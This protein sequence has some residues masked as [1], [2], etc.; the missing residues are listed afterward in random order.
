MKKSPVKIT[1]QELLEYNNKVRTLA[2]KC[3]I[4]KCH[5][6]TKEMQRKFPNDLIFAY[7]EA[8]YSAEDTRGLSQKE[9]KKRYRSASAKLRRLLYRLRAIEEKYRFAIRNEYYWFSGQPRK[10]FQL[11]IE[12]VKNG[13]KSAYYSQG[14]GAIEVAYRYALKG[15][16][17]LAKKWSKKSEEAWLS[18]FKIQSNWYNSY[19]FFGKALGMQG[20]RKEMFEALKKASAISGLELDSEDF[21]AVQTEVGR[22]LKKL[23]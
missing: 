9:V 12:C 2:N 8:V 20:K 22:A 10:Q 7:K 6:L 13:N 15:N 5:Q 23:E 14:V 16:K 3:E 18:Y 11:G 17:S 4:Q 21:V 1:P 19:L